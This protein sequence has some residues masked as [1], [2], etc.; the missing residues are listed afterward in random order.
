MDFKEIYDKYDKLK[1]HKDYMDYE[2]EIATNIRILNS[3]PF[4]EEAAKKQ[5]GELIRKYEKEI[6]AVA[7]LLGNGRNLVSNP[8]KKTSSQ[9][10]DELNYLNSLIPLFALERTGLSHIL[11]DVIDKMGW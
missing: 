9:T 2:N 4:D 10:W 3:Y 8:P 6:N 5:N 7:I 1:T 11:K